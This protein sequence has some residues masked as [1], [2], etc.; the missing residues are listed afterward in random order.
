MSRVLKYQAW[1]LAFIRG[2]W[3]CFEI[4]RASN[5]KM[6]KDFSGEFKDARVRLNQR[7]FPGESPR[8]AP[9]DI[10]PARRSFLFPTQPKGAEGGSFSLVAPLFSI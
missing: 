1:T 5:A 3:F 2:G 10:S 6:R 9:P 4:R 7:A 8:S